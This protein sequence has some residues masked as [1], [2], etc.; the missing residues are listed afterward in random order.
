MAVKFTKEQQLAI[1]TTDKSILVSA[2][3]GS[4]KTAVLV[5]RILS[6]ILEG[7]ANVDEML[8][9]T[10]TKAA[11]AEMRLRLAKAIRARM[12][13]HPEESRRLK[14]QIGR[15][16]RAY[17]S[18]IDSFALRVIREFFY[19]TDIEPDFG[20]CDE[21]QGELMKREAI[22]ELFDERF[23]D[24]DFRDFLRL[25]SEERS[26]DNI[27]DDLLS[28]YGRLRS[29]PDYFNW[30]YSRAEEL[31]VTKE[32]FEGSALQHAMLE[33]ALETFAK[34]YETT[35]K[36]RELMCFSALEAMYDEKLSQETN[37]IYDVLQELQAGNLDESVMAMISGITY[38]QLRTKKG[39]KEAFEP[40]K[41]EAKNLREMYKGIIKD[42]VTNYLSPDLETRLAEMNA[43]Y[44]YTVYY[45]GLL[46]DF[47][48][49][50]AAKKRERKVM[51]FADMEHNAVRILGNDTAAETLRRRF[52]FVFIDEY[53]DTNNIQEYLIG[54]VS[55]PD[56]VFK[57]GDVK[58]SIYKFRQ[59][60]PE[61]F[62]R[63][64]KEF[65]DPANTDGIAI[66]LSKNFRSNDATIRYINRVF[67]KIMEGYD[68]RAM[69]YTGCRCIEEYDFK[70]EVHV[71]TTVENEEDAAEPEA[72]DIADE[73]GEVDEE[74]EDLSK[75]EAEAAYIADLA[76]SL[77]G[78]E[79]HDTKADVVRKAHARDIVILFRAVKTRGDIMA[80]AL[81]KRGIESH[82]EES[83]DYF[84]T[85]EIGVALSLLQCI[86]NMKRDVPL[87]ASLHSEAFGWTPEE[88]ALIRIAHT[89]HLRNAPKDYKGEQRPYIRPAYWEALDWYRTDGPEGALRDKAAYAYDKIME[90]R[91]LSR[92]M[93]LEDFVWKVLTD[94][95][96]Y[97]M[98]GAMNGGARRQANLRSL[99]DR[100]GKYSRETV[101][102]LSSYIAFID[103]MK[104]KKISNGQ[105]SMVGSDDDVIRISTIHKSKGLEYPFVIVGGLG[106]NFK[107][108]GSQKTF[109]FDSSVG[110]SLSYVDPERRYWRSTLMQK[111]IAAKAKRDSYS[112]ELRILYV[113]MTRARNKL[114]M[115]GTCDSLEKLLEY[116][117]TPRNYLK[118]I[119]ELVMTPDN[120]YFIKPLLM[121]SAGI[122]QYTLRKWEDLIPDRLTDEEQALYSEI[123][124]RFTFEYP[125]NDLLTAKAKYSV[126][127]VRRE[128]LEAAKAE[129]EPEEPVITTKDTEPVFLWNASESRKKASAAD[130]GIA[131]HRIMEF[132]DM[133]KVLGDDG[134][135]RSD[136]IEE[137]AAFL[138]EHGAIE[139]DVMKGVD[140]S[141]IKA[142]F[143]SDIGMRVI[144]A[145]A[146]GK[147]RREKPFT[148]RTARGGREILVQGVIDCCFEEDGRMILIDYKS[149]FIRKDRDRSEE[150][151][152]IRNEYA[153]QIELY[154]EAVSKGT[155][156]DVA[157]A[158]LYLFET[159]DAVQML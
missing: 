63:V 7:K 86:D 57:V 31:L 134:S 125:D 133:N 35:G 78:T 6:I 30:A 55:R 12:R 74:I 139:A 19:E 106:H 122:S 114:I 90:W 108:D 70:P 75:E 89:E 127:A 8:V 143:E 33:D 158:Y 28:A 17:I 13:E 159:G 118:V 16:Y 61:I 77:I 119:R 123:D 149:S 154:S 82:V 83:D 72:A 138:T 88:L 124:K 112:E 97:R 76:C 37:T 45:I 38:P 113:A 65:S 34:A 21:V 15:L 103:V 49:R 36:L 111:A 2:A 43:A 130:I 3:A 147:L 11:A 145:A 67:G 79:F 105:A 24:D 20:T 1:D 48:A 140:T 52:R 73:T 93:T 142:F 102:S 157:E 80:R 120:Q 23:A 84:D 50:Y 91:R 96:Y 131:Y 41:E 69:L 25:Y 53:Q 150:I 27:K 32:T 59:A 115:T 155:G 137:R 62:E 121:K 71:L 117:Q 144:A 116:T 47:E 126:S 46:E 136:Y 9:V 68:E 44:K 132:L 135:V 85:V 4:G 104:K 148:L 99:A 87:I 66:D 54:K 109:S 152:R 100:A 156:M 92:M 22:A 14:D 40:I 56:N 146:A 151:R 101:S 141:K 94:S 26:E 153:V 107:S 58:Q 81:R 18:T 60:E 29:I 39:Q 5:E 42:W 128:E 64:Y 110:V 95:G 51:D 129:T 10:F 98:A